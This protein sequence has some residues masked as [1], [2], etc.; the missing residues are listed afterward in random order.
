MFEYKQKTLNKI[1]SFTG[2]GL[3]LGKKISINLK[4]AEVDTGIVF[5]RTDIKNN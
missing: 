5:K 1:I 2:T 4:P 3:H